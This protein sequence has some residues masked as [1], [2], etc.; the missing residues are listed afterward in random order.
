METGLE[1]LLLL[2]H[3]NLSPQTAIV[4][5]AKSKVEDLDA[6][7]VFQLCG[8]DSLPEGELRHRQQR[9]HCGRLARDLDAS[10]V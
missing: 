8:R 5:I 7:A 3:N 4:R 9:F 6:L 1:D 10:R 2:V